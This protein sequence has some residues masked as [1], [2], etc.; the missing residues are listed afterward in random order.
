MPAPVL[1]KSVSL[2]LLLLIA[3][4]LSSAQF[5][6]IRINDP[7]STTPE[8]VTIAINPAN[9]S[10]LAAG[11]NIN[12]YY[13][14]TNSGQT[15]TQS[16]LA[17]SSFGV[18]GD[19][20]TIFDASGHLYYAHLSNPPS[21]GY[22]IDRIVVQK[23]TDGGSTWNQGV[24][25]G[26]NPP[27]KEQ[28]K[29]WLA[30]DMTNSPYRNNLY[31]AWTE[32]DS[33]G[34][35]NPLDSTRILFSRSTDAGLSWSPPV[36]LSEVGGDCID[37]DNTVEGAVPAVGPNGEVYIAWSGPLGIMLDRSTNGG[38]TWGPD[39]F[40]SDQPGGWDYAI[41]GIY[42]ANGL[43]ITACDVSNS[44]YRGNV[45]VQWTDHRNGATNTDAFISRS[46]DGGTTWGAPVRVND[47]TTTREQFFSWMTVDQTN[48][49]IYVVFYDRRNTT[50]NST[51]VY[52]AKSH[53]GGQT[54]TN[55]KVSTSSFLPNAGVFFG[56][57]TNIAAY[58][59]KIYPIW[60]RLDASTL[61]VWT[62]LVM[63]TTAVLDTTTMATIPVTIHDGWNL[64]SVPVGLG[65]T[66]ADSLFPTAVSSGYGYQQHY[67]GEDS[68]RPGLGYWMKFNASEIDTFV[69]KK[70]FAETTAVDVRWN[71]I[72][73]ISVPVAVADVASI[74]P[75]LVTS[76]FYGY[77][78][79]G[80][81]IADSIRPGMAYWVKTISAGDLI[82]DANHPPL[83]SRINIAH[84][85]ELPPPPPDMAPGGN[86]STSYTL[87]QNYPNPFN[88]TTII[89]Y[90]LPEES[91][92]QLVVYNVIG[93]KVRTIVDGV[94][95]K[96]M[97]T[98]SFDAA[99]LPGGVYY[100]RFSAGSFAESRTMLLIK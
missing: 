81:V 50:G 58:N 35:S 88:G 40:V 57:Y 76:D 96:G 8:E 66:A 52:V 91:H 12:Y 73:S 63:D 75:G 62:A 22:W 17:S 46:T 43:P 83:S 51:D 39:I 13:Y 10:Q 21:G 67:I 27:T 28:D 24:G 1:Q 7:A 42:R 41:A 78:G 45:Y 53:D 86:V 61:S 48:G 93:Q 74:P 23:S 6:N 5:P 87:E 89:R 36:R 9:P 84:S 99:A 100:Y 18:W 64:V 60:M 92:V 20:C 44:P 56:D 2:M 16:T 19:P 38:V 65:S 15:W 71:L 14:S 85:S 94:Q 25:I 34:S 72:G 37:E 79:S 29:E 68:L 80:Y 30:V 69:G 90:E 55:F 3:A 11:A 49:Y 82:L 70:I 95:G 4:S 32:F 98:A 77:N 26:Y 54:F 31:V 33:Y 97:K 59:G 47:D